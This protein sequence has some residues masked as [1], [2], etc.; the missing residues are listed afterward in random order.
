MSFTHPNTNRL[1]AFPS[2]GLSSPFQVL[3]FTHSKNTPIGCLPN[4]TLFLCFSVL[5]SEPT[6]IPPRL[7]VLS[8]A[9]VFFA[10][11]FWGFYQPQIPPVGCLPVPCPFALSLLFGF[12]LLCTPNPPVCCLPNPPRCL[13]FSSLGLVALTNCH[14]SVV[15]GF[16]GFTQPKSQKVGCPNPRTF[17]FNFWGFTPLKCHWL[18]AFL[19]PP[20]SLLFGFW[21]LTRPKSPHWLPSSNP[22]FLCFRFW[23]STRPKFPQ[24]C[25]V[26]KTRAFLAFGFGVLP[27]PYSPGWLPSKPP[28][29]S[30]LF[31]F[32]FYL[33]G[34]PRPV[35]FR[36][37][38]VFFAFQ[39]LGF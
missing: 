12:V 5:E 27:A 20:L 13:C 31:K 8:K 4:P 29:L 35:A 23:S 18:I 22:C 39:F 37:T 30:L 36:T 6:Q 9:R 7:V 17:D 11:V 15:F 26:P 2:P 33:P 32:G 21:D 16:C 25:C 19:F 1:I 24:I 14:A 10:F 3:G 28:A 34:I 38:H